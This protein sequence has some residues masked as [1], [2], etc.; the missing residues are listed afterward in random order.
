M[1]NLLRMPISYSRTTPTDTDTPNGINPLQNG[2]AAAGVG[3]GGAAAAAAGFIPVVGQV[4]AVVG[5][6]VSIAQGLKEQ[7]DLN[8]YQAIMVSQQLQ[9]E[10]LTAELGEEALAGNL[11]LERLQNQID[12]ANEQKGVATI[13]ILISATLLGI[14]A[15]IFAFKIKR[16]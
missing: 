12:V 14:T 7:Q 3:V 9:K 4:V 1:K 2:N 6:V 8:A 16:K 13:G 11:E 10:I 15:F 5:A